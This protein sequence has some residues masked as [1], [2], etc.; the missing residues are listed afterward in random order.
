MKAPRKIKKLRHFLLAVLGSLMLVA[1]AHAQAPLGTAEFLSSYHFESVEGNNASAVAFIPGPNVY[2]T[3]IAGNEAFPLE[4]FDAQGNTIHSQE[5]GLDIRGI[6]YNP[7]TKEL[8]ANAIGERGWYSMTLNEKGIPNGDWQVIRDGQFQPDEQSVLSYVTPKKKL[9]TFYK[10]SFSFWGRSNG[11]EKIRYQ[12]GTPGNTNWY[13]V[14]TTAAYT[15][16]D[17]YPIGVLELNTGQILYFDLK[18]K[19]LGA[20]L[21]PNADPEIT[22]FRF[23]FANRQA[24]IFDKTDRIWRIYRVF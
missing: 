6:W 4:V 21:I 8:E 1:I 20:T 24:F 7:T 11:K 15:G 16:N 17:K 13:I 5:V 23:A 14:P 2:I 3:V 18:G 10:G 9:V 22:A 19:Y 12:H